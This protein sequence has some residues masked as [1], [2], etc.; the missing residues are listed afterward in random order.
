MIDDIL[1]GKEVDGE[2]KDFLDIVGLSQ[3]FGTNPE[4]TQQKIDDEA[5][6]KK[7]T[8]WTN[9]AYTRA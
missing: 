8:D 7:N 3:A 6:T 4:I 5:A 1:A 2:Y 9:S